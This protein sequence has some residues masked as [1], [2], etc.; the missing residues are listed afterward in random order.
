MAEGI[1]GASQRNPRFGYLPKM[2]ERV[3]PEEL[4]NCLGDWL[5]CSCE[6]RNRSG[7]MV[8]PSAA[9]KVRIGKPTM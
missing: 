8:K 5:E 9:A 2:F 6:E 3:E 4:S 7:W 1:S